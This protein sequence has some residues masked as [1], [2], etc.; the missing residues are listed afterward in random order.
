MREGIG[1]WGTAADMARFVGFNLF[2]TSAAQKRASLGPPKDAED[3]ATRW[4]ISMARAAGGS[5]AR[6][7][8][9]LLRATRWCGCSAARE[10]EPEP[11]TSWLQDQGSSADRTAMRKAIVPAPGAQRLSSAISVAP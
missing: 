8:A 1:V 11:A 4:N 9:A 10:A 2:E 7:P 6:A 5:P 3:P